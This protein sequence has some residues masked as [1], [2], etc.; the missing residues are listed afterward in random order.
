M[1][2]EGSQPKLQ[3]EHKY[4]LNKFSYAQIFKIFIYTRSKLA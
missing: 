3:S 4:F 2:Q 1:I